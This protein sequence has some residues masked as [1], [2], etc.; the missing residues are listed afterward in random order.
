MVKKITDGQSVFGGLKPFG[1][2]YFL[3]FEFRNVLLHQIIEL[4]MPF[5]DL[6]LSALI[7][8]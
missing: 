5:I 2:L 3:P 8:H 6:F 4:Q 7:L 1:G